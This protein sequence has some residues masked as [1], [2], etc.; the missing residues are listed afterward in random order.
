MKH[1]PTMRLIGIAIVFFIALALIN[2]YGWS[3]IFPCI[4]IAF[5]TVFAILGRFRVFFAL[6]GIFVLLGFILPAID[7]AAEARRR[8]ICSNN[9][10]QIASAIRDYEIANGFLPQP[11][12]SSD[13]GER[14][15][16]WRVLL[17][18]YLGEKELFEQIDQSKPWDD[19]ANIKIGERMPI[20]FRCH[21]SR[22]QSKWFTIGNATSYVAVVGPGTAWP[23][24]GLRTTS[25]FFDP[26]AINIIVLESDRHQ[27]HWMSP[28]DPTMDQFLST[29]HLHNPHGGGFHCVDLRGNTRF[30]SNSSVSLDEIRNFLT[31]DLEFR[32]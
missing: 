30:L 6:L 12:I 25:S 32:P 7:P 23:T 2:R 22:R 1:R 28:N 15:L 31:L 18:P 9:L 5:T 21:E 4:Y 10:R 3:T 26:E 27:V 19:P 14:L 24:T 8:M 13:T 16:S 29:M 11:F 17:L 20:L